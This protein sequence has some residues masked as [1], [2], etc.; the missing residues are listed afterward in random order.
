M[1][2]ISIEKNPI[3]IITPFG[4]I[5]VECC[6]WLE[7]KSE[8]IVTIDCLNN[9]ADLCLTVDDERHDLVKFLRELEELEETEE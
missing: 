2:Y 1:N 3:R 6:N 7:K 9:E 5:Y 4:E 8:L